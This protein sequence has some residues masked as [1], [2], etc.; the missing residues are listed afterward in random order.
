MKMLWTSC[1]VLWIATSS[2]CRYGVAAPAVA[3]PAVAD[4]AQAAHAE[5]AYVHWLEEHSMLHQAQTL[6]RRYSGNRI[7]WQHPYGE[8]QPRAA[9]ARSS[10]WFTAYPAS[11]IS[12]APGAS[13]LATLADERLWNAFQTIG[14][15][16]VHAIDRWQF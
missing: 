11:T 15:Q 8:P 7:Q 5:S 9:S 10:V 13:V 2:V 6:A 3:A 14:I 1:V 4:T 12:A 16:A